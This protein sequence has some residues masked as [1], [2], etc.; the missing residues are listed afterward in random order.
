MLIYKQDL[1]DWRNIVSATA[2]KLDNRKIANVIQVGEK[3]IKINQEGYLVN[4][5]DWNEETA[6]AMAEVDHLELSDCHW[7]AINFMR[8][9]YREYEVP[10]PPRVVIKAIGDKINARGCS[11]KTLEQTFPLGGCKQ[12]CRLA[13]LPAY[14]CHA[15]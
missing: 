10:P 4:F 6:K 5:G 13:G 3:Q 11:N 15:C 9:F 2:I 1:L 7:I 12:A 8:N 14:Y